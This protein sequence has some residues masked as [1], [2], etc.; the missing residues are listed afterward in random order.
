[1]EREAGAFVLP[2]LVVGIADIMRLKREL[3]A[4]YEYLHQSAL[5]HTAETELKLPKTS[6]VLDELIKANKLDLLKREQ[7]ELVMAQLDAIEQ[8]APQIHLSFSSDPSSA[9]IVRIVEWLRQNIHPGV[10]VQIGLQP[11]LAAGCVVRTTNKQFDLSLKHHFET[12][13][14]MLIQKLQEGAAA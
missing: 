14:P 8:R 5:R 10:L 7:Y 11:T 1:M 4:L 12:A 3:D 13:R 2:P 9:F 6:R